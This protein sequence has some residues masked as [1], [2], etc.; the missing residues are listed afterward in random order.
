MRVTYGIEVMESDDIY[1]EAAERAMDTVIIT[2][3]P[4]AFVVDRLPICMDV[5][6][7]SPCS[8]TDGSLI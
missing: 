4:G 6:T 8:G 2:G 3:V 7:L 1:I 5:F